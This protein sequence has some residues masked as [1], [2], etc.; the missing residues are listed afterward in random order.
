ML[1]FCRAS[2]T[3]IPTTEDPTPSQ[4]EMA[5]TVTNGPRYGATPTVLNLPP[6]PAVIY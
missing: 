3:N 5:A 1:A 2:A 4:V 6:S